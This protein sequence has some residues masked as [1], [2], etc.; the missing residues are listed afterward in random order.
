MIHNGDHAQFEIDHVGVAPKDRPDWPM[1]SFDAMDWAEAFNKI[2]P[3][4]PVDV[5]LPWFAAALMRGYDE[6]DIRSDVMRF[7]GWLTADLHE[8]HNTHPGTLSDS[9]ERFRA[10][11]AGA[12]RCPS[13]GVNDNG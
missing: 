12:V 4:V 1:P 7:C 6:A 9:W 2:N 5:A 13:P 8:L 3:A 10:Q 11:R